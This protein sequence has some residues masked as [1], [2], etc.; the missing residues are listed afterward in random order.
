VAGEAELLG[1]RIPVAGLAGDQ[2]SALFGQ[3][4]F[5]PG[6]AKATYGTGSFV[7]VNQGGDS[8]PAP[9][10][11]LKTAA[12]Q[13]G[14]FALE[15]AVFV[16]G[17]ALQW[18][19]D[20]LGLIADAA[21]SEALARSVE[22]TGGVFF[23]PALT[24]LGSPHWDPDARGLICGVT[25]GTTRAHLVR[26]A[27]EAIALQVADVVGASGMAPAVLRADGGAA[28]NGWLMQLQA[29]L[30]GA[31]VEVSAEREMTAL[32]AAGLAG[33]AVGMWES[34]A[35]LETAWRP[36]ARFEPSMSPD[37]VDELTAGWR[38]A[39]ARTRLQM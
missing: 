5:S 8:A 36:G 22:S 38:D 12:A 18:L 20:G 34:P 15:G 9:H 23:V 26:A 11:L 27:L 25:R 17:A 19:R 33:L 29:D 21:E 1:T 14:T 7:L 24:G 30:L 39:L 37:R 32:G 13:Q 28:A 3:A 2:Q 35:A 16:A 6:D 4:C 10:G 31:P